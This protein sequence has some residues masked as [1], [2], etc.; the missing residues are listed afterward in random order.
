[1]RFLVTLSWP[2]SNFSCRKAKAERAFFDPVSG[3]SE[4]TFLP[5]QYDS[6]WDFRE[7]YTMLCFFSR[8]KLS[9]ASPEKPAQK[10]SAP[11]A[12]PSRSRQSQQEW[13][14]ALAPWPISYVGATRRRGGASVSREAAGRLLATLGSSVARLWLPPPVLVTPQPLPRAPC[15]PFWPSALPS[16][17][18]ACRGDLGPDRISEDA[19]ATA[20]SGGGRWRHGDVGR[21]PGAGSERGPWMILGSWGRGAAGLPWQVKKMLRLLNFKYLLKLV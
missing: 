14:R 13:R 4:R 18:P 19:P 1:M 10:Q 17:L 21:V 15:P 12:T 7:L 11:P 20:G 8:Q 3:D 9:K 2:F 16:A 5:Y 6:G